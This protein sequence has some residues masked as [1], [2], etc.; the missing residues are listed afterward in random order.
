MEDDEKITRHKVGTDC[1]SILEGDGAINN[2]EDIALG[3]KMFMDI[4][5]LLPTDRQKFVALALDHG[6]QKVDVA[7][8]LTLSSSVVSRETQKMQKTLKGY[9]R[10]RYSKN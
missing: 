7:Y 8:M 9:Y 6:F 10:R 2:A 5:K 1:L 4:I 3:D